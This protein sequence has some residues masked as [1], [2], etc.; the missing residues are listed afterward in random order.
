MNQEFPTP[1]Y[2][3]MRRIHLLE[4]AADDQ[5]ERLRLHAVNLVA[6]VR[7]GG[8]VRDG[9]SAIAAKAGPAGA[10]VRTLIAHWATRGRRRKKSKFPW[11]SATLASLAA[12]GF[13][14]WWRQRH[15]ED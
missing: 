10:I 13:A 12:A 2:L 5:R 6:D 3:R 9:L 14:H 4:R 1:L 7:G 15:D 8:L 11:L